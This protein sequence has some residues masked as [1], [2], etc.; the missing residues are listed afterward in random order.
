MLNGRCTSLLKGPRL[1]N[2]LYVEWDVIPYHTIVV[3]SCNYH[4]QAIRHFR[5]LLMME[6]AQT[7]ACSLNLSRKD[8]CNAVLHGAPTGTIQ[9]LQRVQNNAARIVLQAPR[10]FHAKPLLHQL[11]WLPVQQR[12][13]YKLPV[14]TYKVWS[15][16]TTVYLHCR[17]AERA[18]SRTL[19]SSAIPLLDQLFM[20]TDFSRR[21][22]R[23]SAPTVWNSL[24]Q[25]VLISDSLSVFN[26]DLKLFCSIRLL[27]N[28][29]LTCR[30]RL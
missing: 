19:R 2:D 7:L 26:P 9:K 14:L 3:R 30:Q 4:P 12:I 1:R 27:L 16:S 6:L 18:C 15:T 13:T 5:H 11:H 20:R 10:R 24:P 8:Y 29:D 23:F 28:T 17:I 25:T 21:A 22:F